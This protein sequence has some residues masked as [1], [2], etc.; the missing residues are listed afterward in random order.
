FP[1]GTNY[2][3]SKTLTMSCR[4]EMSES[5]S[6]ARTVTEDNDNITLSE[7]AEP[8]DDSLSS[9]AARL[10]SRQKAKRSFAQI[11]PRSGQRR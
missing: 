9:A 7:K 11:S 4:G 8:T 2:P 5:I 10:Y 6:R 1:C 3:L